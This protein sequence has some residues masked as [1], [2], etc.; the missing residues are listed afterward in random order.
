VDPN[1]LPKAANLH[2]LGQKAYA[3][4]PAFCKGFDLCLM[5]FALNES[6]EYINPTKALEYMATGRE[7]ISTAVPDVVHNFGSVV[8]IARSKEEFVLMCETALD[9]PDAEAIARG[10][11]MAQ[12][13]SWDSIVAQLEE[14]MVEA[15]QR[16]R[17]AA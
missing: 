10:L 7:I 6:T 17:T 11:K 9:Q 5:P 15:L 12:Q 4:L 2:W 14:H 1:I 8:K 13:N 3:E 16:K